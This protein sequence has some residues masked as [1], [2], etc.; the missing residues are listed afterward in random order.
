MVYVDTILQS[1]C[2]ARPA[3]AVPC[4]ASRARGASYICMFFTY[5]R[6]NVGEFSHFRI[7]SVR[8]SPDPSVSLRC[9]YMCS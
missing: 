8:R 5:D 1:D 6:A 9:V 2:R 4:R 3:G 7:P